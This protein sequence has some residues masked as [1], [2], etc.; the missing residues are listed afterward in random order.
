MTDKIRIDMI[1]RYFGGKMRPDEIADFQHRLGSDPALRKMM[2]AEELIRTTI[3]RDLDAI[4]T[5]HPATRMRVMDMLSEARQYAPA[6]GGATT[7]G[8][9]MGAGIS[10]VTKLILGSVLG[11]GL[12]TGGYMALKSDRAPEPTPAVS[13][14]VV[15]LTPPQAVEDGTPDAPAVK[16]ESEAPVALQPAPESVT[17]QPER[18]TTREE[19]RATPRKSSSTTPSE[20]ST[21]QSAAKASA[22]STSEKTEPATAPASQ[23]KKE[24]PRN[25]RVIQKETVPIDIQ[26]K[27]QNPK[28]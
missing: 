15:P 4:P 22:P 12:V 27:E 7:G 26:V 28:R 19:A 14:P 8:A 11:L 3:R 1:G 25:P 5:N 20:G 17:S 21:R 2:D 10:S 9:S 13:T 24:T 6:A 16:E 18:A 23:P